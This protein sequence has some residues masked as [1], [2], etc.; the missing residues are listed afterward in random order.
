MITQFKHNSY[1]WSVTGIGII[2]VLAAICLPD[3]KQTKASETAASQPANQ[4]RFTKIRIPNRIPYD[5]QLSPDGKSIALG[6]EK[7]L[8]I[9]PMVGPL[10]PEY[11]GAP[12]LLNTGD[13]EVEWAGFAWSRDGRWIAFNDKEVIHAEKRDGNQR[14]YVVS[15]EG[16]VPREV[17]ETYRDVRIV[18]YR[19]SLS[20]DGKTL[21]FSSVD[22]NEL[23]IY[24]IGVD[25]GSPRRLVD[26]PAREPVFSPD[27]TK[28]AYV[29][30]KLLGRV[31]GGLWVVPAEGGTPKLVAE[32]GNASSPV[33]SPDGRR[34][35]F[36]D[37]NTPRQ[38]CLVP[39]GETG[40]QAGEMTRIN[41]PE[42]FDNVSR[43]TGWTPDNKIGA[44]LAVHQEF[45]LYTLPL[46][47]GQAT[48]VARG[49]Y[50]PQPRW[51]PDG[52]R[53]I[54][55]VNV[56]IDP[57]GRDGWV[58]FGLA[59]V[60]SQGGEATMIPVQADAKIVG[61]PW[62][63]GNHVSP[64]GK[65]IVFAGRRLQEGIHTMHIWT[66]P[67]E[68][69]EPRQL[70]NA[71]TPLTDWGP[72]WSPDGKAIA[73]VRCQTSDNWETLFAKPGICIIPADGGEPRQ[74]TRE[75]DMVHFGSIAW[76]PDGK[77]LAYLSENEGGSLRV[78][79]ADGGPSRMVVKLQAI[80]VD[81][82]L[83]WSA[84]S[85]RIAFNDRDRKTIKIVS[86]DEGTTVDI[87]PNLANTSI[88]YLDWSRDG[89]QLVFT[90]SQGGGP[91]F[92]MI[93][94]FLPTTAV[95]GSGK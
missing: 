52:K 83:A 50:Y 38:I 36:L 34:V 17:H 57:K 73:F 49:E 80:H 20:P 6:L 63:G 23:H 85:K 66:L 75:S 88:W 41:C 44:I 92:W 35:A 94:N 21:A 40:E 71:P 46:K 86:L 62:Q 82:E 65:T 68:G 7:K 78:I 79:P 8:W 56:S 2:A 60:S 67:I 19:M 72:C 16:G 27:G 30:D 24:T 58:D 87:K 13:S 70:T 81:I 95:A 1:R 33:W 59:S 18:N 91:E 45:G 37:A 15:A 61:P 64:D 22:A 14:M 31:G 90:G 11:P 26:A 51:S 12:V 10:G 32:A 89:E 47:G 48:L 5:A 39:I 29:E 4:P 3:A 93:E 74:L 55:S 54:H 42:G 69:G 9:V 43:L 77:L 25:G 53:I 28:I 84:D 76:S